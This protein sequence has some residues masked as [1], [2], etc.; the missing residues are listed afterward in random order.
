MAHLAT[1]SHCVGAATAC[2]HTWNEA[3]MG[4]GMRQPWL[5]GQLLGLSE[6]AKVRAGVAAASWNEVSEERVQAGPPNEPQREHAHSHMRWRRAGHE[7]R[8]LTV[9]MKLVHQPVRHAPGPAMW[10]RLRSSTGARRRPPLQSPT[11]ARRH[12]SSPPPELD[13]IEAHQREHCPRTPVADRAGC[14]VASP[15]LDGGEHAVPE[16]RV[17]EPSV[18]PVCHHRAKQPRL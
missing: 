12:P 17:L 15:R 7:L 11:R 16:Q 14:G 2:V 4:E 8:E 1:Q 3:S 9:P 10:T 18:G 13:H 5:V 6:R